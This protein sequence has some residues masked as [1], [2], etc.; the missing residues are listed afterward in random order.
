MNKNKQLVSRTIKVPVKAVPLCRSRSAEKRE[1]LKNF[2]QNMFLGV[3]LQ[4]LK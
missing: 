2:N 3:A 4:L 1:A